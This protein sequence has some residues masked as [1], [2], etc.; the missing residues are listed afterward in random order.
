ME[1]ICYHCITPFLTFLDSHLGLF[2][3]QY[4]NKH[5]LVTTSVISSGMLSSL[6]LSM[7]VNRVPVEDVCRV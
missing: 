1:T 3:Y 5:E 2:L 4:F 7:T 6:S